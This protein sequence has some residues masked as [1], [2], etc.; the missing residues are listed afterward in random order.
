[1]SATAPIST[2]TLGAELERDR[3]ELRVGRITAALGVLRRRESENRRGPGAPRRRLGQAI[4]DF[5]AQIEAMK[6]RLRDLDMDGPSIQI[7][8]GADGHRY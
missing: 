6:A 8:R 3:L 5:E 4:A 7:Q 2:H 1:M